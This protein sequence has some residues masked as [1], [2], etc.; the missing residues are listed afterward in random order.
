MLDDVIGRGA[1]QRVFTLRILLAFAAV[2]IVLAALGLYGVL[3]YGVRLRA[4][5]FSIR[6]ALGA[7]R[8]A[9]RSMVLRRG[10]IVAAIGIALGLGGAMSLSTLMASVLFQVS[11]LDPSVLVGATVFMA[12]VAGFAAYVPAYRATTMD[13]RSALQ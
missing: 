13:P 2:A 10:L 4:R 9:I 3:S 11:P 7:E 8:G 12:I 1:A 5:E 6:M